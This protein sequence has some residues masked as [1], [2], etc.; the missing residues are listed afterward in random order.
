MKGKSRREGKG[1]EEERREM[2]GRE[3]KSRI[4]VGEGKEREGK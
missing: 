1:R 2:T 3:G 4:G